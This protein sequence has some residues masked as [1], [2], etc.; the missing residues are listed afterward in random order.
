MPSKTGSLQASGSGYY[1][2]VPV[3]IIKLACI[4]KEEMSL[5]S[6]AGLVSSI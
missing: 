4:G 1:V 6:V 5:V 2:R 3:K